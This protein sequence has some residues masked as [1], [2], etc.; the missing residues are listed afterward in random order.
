MSS[1]IL[2]AGSAQSLSELTGSPAPAPIQTNASAQNSEEFEQF[3]NLLL[4]QL[5]NQ[6]PLDPMDTED[7]TAQLTQF[8]QLEQSIATN[9]NLERLT[10]LI[11]SNNDFN[12]VS[13]LGSEVTYNAKF[14]PVQN[15]LAQWDYTFKEPITSYRVEISNLEGDVVFA[16]E[17]N[18]VTTPGTYSLSFDGFE[19][20]EDLKDGQILSLAVV[21]VGD[22]GKQVPATIQ[23]KAFVE[24]LDSSSG[25][26]I[27]RAGDISLNVSDIIRVGAYAPPQFTAP[28]PAND[29]SGDGS[30]DGTEGAGDSGDSSGDTTADNTT[31]TSDDNDGS[32]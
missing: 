11:A 25:V 27:L 9:D 13:Y 19:A 24:A 15:T 31:D 20:T 29:G 22:G 12:A 32:A 3:L 10:S 1:V 30:G 6:D 14:A 28:P 26:P 7:Y 23:G 21:G 16:S 18:E 17:V 5:Q 4:I 8:S 2:P